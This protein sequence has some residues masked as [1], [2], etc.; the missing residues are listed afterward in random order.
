MRLDPGT[1]RRV[2]EPIAVEGRPTGVAVGG[3][4]VWVTARDRDELVRIEP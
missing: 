2:G 3:G 1:G 4:S